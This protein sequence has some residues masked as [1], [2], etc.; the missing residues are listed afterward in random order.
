MAI[1]R[2][3]YHRPVPFVLG[4]NFVGVVHETSSETSHWRLGRRVAGL[5]LG[6]SNARYLTTTT[7]RLF[8]VPKNLD[9][10][11]I[12]CIQSVFLPAFQA[13]QHGQPRPWRYSDTSLRKKRIL[14]TEGDLPETLAILRMAH[15]GG[16]QEVYVVAERDR[17]KALRQ[18]NSIPLDVHGDDWGPMVAENMDVVVDFDFALNGK[19]A[20]RA[21]A[22]NGRLVWSRHPDKREKTTGHSCYA[23]DNLWEQTKM[24]LLERASLY[25]LYESWNEH[26]HSFRV[27]TCPIVD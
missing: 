4:S 10:S 26:P 3:V 20:Y 23:N 12:A 11:E 16:A 17:H 19:A 24:C 9:A 18:M 21:L 14:I 27:S 2:G 6:G 22:P 7:E 13:L 25:D 8:D 5:S 15:Y 1:R